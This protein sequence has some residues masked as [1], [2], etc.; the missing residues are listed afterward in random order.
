MMNGSAVLIAVM[1][2]MM[3]VMCGGIVVGAAI[4]LTRLRPGRHDK[5]ARDT[6]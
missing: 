5:P 6:S 1:V 2:V 3:I 4:A